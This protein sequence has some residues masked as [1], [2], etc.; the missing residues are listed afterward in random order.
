MQPLGGTLQERP[1]RAFYSLPLADDAPG[2]EASEEERAVNGL[3]ALLPGGRKKPGVDVR[4][5]VA[6]G[7]G[8]LARTCCSAG[9]GWAGLGWAGLGCRVLA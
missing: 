7:G 1:R 6:V 2:D 9:L 3:Q 4:A 5:R 8:L